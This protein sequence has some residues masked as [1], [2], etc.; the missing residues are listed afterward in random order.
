M[1]IDYSSLKFP[2]NVTIYFEHVSDFIENVVEISRLD[3]GTMAI[4]FFKT[5]NGDIYEIYE[6]R[7]CYIIK[8]KA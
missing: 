3:R 8:Q 2:L 6:D 5:K 1:I 7:I 4:L